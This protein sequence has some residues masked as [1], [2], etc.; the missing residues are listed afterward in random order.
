MIVEECDLKTMEHIIINKSPYVHLERDQIVSEIV[1]Q[2]S[3]GLVSWICKFISRFS[4][5]LNFKLSFKS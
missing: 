4:M 5:T 1:K 3:N 2:D